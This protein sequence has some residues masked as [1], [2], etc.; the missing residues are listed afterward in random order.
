MQV[1]IDF[2]VYKAL[3]AMRLHERHTYNDVLR[4]LLNLGPLLVPEAHPGS[5]QGVMTQVVDHFSRGLIGPPDSFVSRGLHLPDGTK[6]RA[7]YKGSLYHAAIVE[8]RWLDENGKD[9]SSPSSAATDITG[10]NVNGLRFWEAMRP[11]DSEWRRLDML[12]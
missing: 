4:E 12:V 11:G 7:R 10:T 3:T 8:G 6:L 2:E 1:E 5:I 9:H